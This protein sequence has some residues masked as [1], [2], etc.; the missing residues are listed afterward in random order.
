MSK[1]TSNI[2]KIILALLIPIA[3]SLIYCL[4]RGVSLGELYLPASY[5]NDCVYYYKLVGAA[6][7]YGSPTGY[8]GFNESHAA[9]GGFAAWNP[10]IILPWVLWGVVFGWHYSSVFVCNIVLFSLALAAFVWLS[11]IDFKGLAV[12]F[13]MLLLFPSFTIHL[14]NV[15][16][17]VLMASVV[18][19]YLGFAVRAVNRGAKTSYIV[20]MY[21]AAAYLTMVRPYMVLLMI[22]PA[23]Y[24]G[25]NKKK[26]AGFISFVLVAIGSLAANALISKYFSADYFDPLFKLDIVKLVLHGQFSEAYWTATALL[27]K[28]SIS[29]SEAILDAF[30]FGLTMGTQY[31]VAIVTA[32]LMVIFSLKRGENKLRP[33]YLLFSCSTFAVLLSVIF[34]LHKTNEGG[35]HLWV[36]A[37]AGIVIVCLNGF[38]VQGIVSKAVVGLLL[39]VFCLRGAMV[40]TDYD[41]PIGDEATKAN[42]EYW[43]QVF[44]DKNIFSQDAKGYDNTV[45]WVFLDSAGWGQVVTEYDELYSLPTG[46]GISCCYPDYV[47]SNFDSLQSRFILTDS[48]GEV[49]K[50][51]DEKG[52]KV[53]GQHENVIMYQ[54]Y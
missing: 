16:P 12:L 34:F 7:R 5:N 41:I 50:L 11:E 14:L 33:I 18:L 24:L 8:F 15:L 27:K 44:E 20:V 39:I 13:V 46:T 40:P 28:M 30:D 21:V 3:V 2:V 52:L 35:R 32:V 48:R 43:Q 1:R 17:E 49:S 26:L 47:I 42:V 31:V 4:I 22:L 51:C 25:K 19:I 6:V 10:L 54:R 29:I 38:K 36:F 45:I 23:Y 53:V 37:F 9:I